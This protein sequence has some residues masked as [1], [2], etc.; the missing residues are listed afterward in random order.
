MKEFDKQYLKF[1]YAID[2]PR[3]S[4]DY[5][6]YRFFEILPGFLIW[7]TLIALTVFSWL[8]PIWA[9]F[10]I[11]AFDVYWLLKTIF[12]SIHLRASYKKM[13]EHTAIDWMERVRGLKLPANELSMSSWEDIHHCVIF[14]CFLEPK[15][16]MEEALIKI[17]ES[18][19]PSEK[20]I[21][22]LAMEESG[23]CEDRRA[24]DELEAKYKSRFFKFLVTYHPSGVDGELP[25][26][27]ANETYA[28]RKAKEG[29]IDPLNIPYERIIV[30][31]LDSDT[32]IYSQY[33]AIVSYHYL[34][35]RDPLHSSFQPI[36]VYNNNIWSAHGLS[37]IVAYSGTFWQMMQQTRPERLT[38]F[39]S[40]SMPFK[41]LVEMDFW[42]VNIV[43]EDSR[44][45]WQS[46]IFYDGRWK[47]EPL[48]YPVSMDANVGKN[49]LHTAKNI[50]KQQ[51][52]WGW[53]VE[54]IPY[55]FFGFMKNKKI[56][57]R[58]KLRFAFNQLEGFWS[59]GTNALIIFLFGWF[60][61]MFGGDVFNMSVLSYNVPRMTRFLMTA[62]MVGVI[63]S[64]IVALRLLPPLPKGH[65][66]RSYIWIVAQ[67]FSLPITLIFFGAIPG[68]E[69]QTRLMLGKY[70]GFW[71]TPKER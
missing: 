42:H 71:R 22:V 23:G 27:G 11:I 25:G 46:L 61:I 68:I 31:S 63:S 62:S 69:A 35:T 24:A 38:T 5:F 8:Y 9:S 40:H 15:A 56:P 17:L 10:F 39:S 12:F 43:S 37:R 28:A 57:K 33:F 2:L 30:S 7:G 54:N 18:T 65:T 53:G 58:M 26:K 36:P 47:V 51:R 67:W 19:Y 64:S 34:T 16:I 59:W 66:W 48:Y 52:R 3:G 4:T 32:Q 45:F 6:L 70:M 49:L 13:Q 20:M 44:I 29:I 1:G 41:A 60:P 14:P 21:M 55:A 50:Y